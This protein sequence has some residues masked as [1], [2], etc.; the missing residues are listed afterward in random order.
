MSAGDVLREAFR[1]PLRIAVITLATILLIVGSIVVWTQI[2]EPARDE[3]AI[4]RSGDRWV[5]GRLPFSILIV[6]EIWTS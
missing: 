1:T 4:L 6:M 5:R 2:I 3:A